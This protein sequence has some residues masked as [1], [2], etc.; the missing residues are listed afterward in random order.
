MVET[1]S[2]FMGFQLRQAG[3]YWEA[4]HG[5]KQVFA[6]PSRRE[7]MKQIVKWAKNAKVTS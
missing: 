4:W 1:K 2:D 7:L 6:N 5:P 3:D